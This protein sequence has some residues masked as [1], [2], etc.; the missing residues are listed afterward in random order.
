LLT[1]RFSR[2][3][4]GAI[5]A[6]NIALRIDRA[7]RLPHDGRSEDRLREALSIF[8]L[9]TATAGCTETT[10][11]APGVSCASDGECCANV[12][13]AA[14]Q[15]E[16]LLTNARCTRDEECCGVGSTCG[17]DKRCQSPA[18]CV[19]EGLSC[20]L[21]P[22]CGASRSTCLAGTCS[23]AVTDGQHCE[24][25]ADCC[26]HDGFFCTDQHECRRV[27]QQVG[28]ECGMIMGR[29]CCDG[30]QCNHKGRCEA[31]DMSMPP[32]LSEPDL[33]M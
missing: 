9:V 28:Q 20:D 5:A 25:Q 24:S 2:R 1:N 16:C 6:R 19:G 12:C 8:V 17:I 21:H 15:C 23:C 11:N 14:G 31:I 4:A 33:S 10:C 26:L 27:C 7:R 30:M 32:D 18:D 13:G 22:C 29:G 3:E